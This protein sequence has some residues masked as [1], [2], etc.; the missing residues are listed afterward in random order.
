MTV[1][2]FVEHKAGVL[3]DS[4]LP[5]LAVAQSLADKLDLAFEAVAMG[6]RGE[7]VA[8]LLANLGVSCLHVTDDER[9]D[10]YAPRAWARAVVEVVEVAEAEIVMAAGTDRG[11]EVLAHVAARLRRP[12]ATNCTDVDPGLPFGVTRQ[13]WGGSLLEVATLDGSPKLLTVLPLG[14]GAEPGTTDTVEPT[15]RRFAPDLSELDLAIA[16]G[17]L[18]PGE[19]KSISLATANVVVGGGRGVG[20]P[21]GF[22]AL[23]E[24]AGLLGAAVGH[25]R[26]VTND[27]WRPHSGQIGMTGTRIAPDLYIACGISGASQHMVAC[28]RAKKIMAINKDP[29]AAILTKADYAIV[30]DLT[31]VVPAM[32]EE[33]RRIVSS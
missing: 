10:R 1:V 19:E 2:A 4:S 24:L 29:E 33:I 7:A 13:R 15:V 6:A 18:E 22:A 5:M 31:K 20:S 25:S 28:G 30:G 32:I 11:N 3:S 14:V 9:L 17:T 21:D 12:L 8:D 26:P 16:V 27:G 23:E